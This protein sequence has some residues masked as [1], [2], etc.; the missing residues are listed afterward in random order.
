MPHARTHTRRHPSREPDPVLR[1]IDTATLVLGV[2]CT[3]IYV[4]MLVVDGERMVTLLTWPFAGI[5]LAIA[6]TRIGAR[7]VRRRRHRAAR[8]KS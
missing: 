8:D 1:R 5:L 4:G 3:W 7:L 2:V 6:V